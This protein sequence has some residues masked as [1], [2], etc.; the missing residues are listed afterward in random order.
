MFVRQIDHQQRYQVIYVGETSDL[1]TRFDSHHAMLCIDRHGA[2]HLWIHPEGME[3]EDDRKAVE[4]DLKQ[5]WNPP[6]NG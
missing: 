6:C 1:S 3:D 5:G 2:T 4:E